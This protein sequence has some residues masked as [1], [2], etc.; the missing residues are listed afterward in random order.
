[1]FGLTVA[2]G[3]A[4]VGCDFW[5]SNFDKAAVGWMKNCLVELMW[6]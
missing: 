6:L 5:K 4:V 3:K 1:V 2:L